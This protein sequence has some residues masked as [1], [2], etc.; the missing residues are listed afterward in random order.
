M[1]RGQYNG[2]L[3]VRYEVKVK[4]GL[5]VQHVCVA[6]DVEGAVQ[7]LFNSTIVSKSGE[8]ASGAARMRDPGWGSAMA[9]QQIVTG[10]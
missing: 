8:E 1:L 7:W 2:F 4:R 6:L 5:A 9:F 3:T 10:I